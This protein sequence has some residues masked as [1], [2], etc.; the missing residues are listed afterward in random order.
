MDDHREGIR[1]EKPVPLWE[2]PGCRE[3]I[4]AEQPVLPWEQSGGFR[5]DCEPHRGKF[6]WW[7]ACASYVVGLLALLPCVGFWPGVI[8][9]PFNLG[10]RYLAGT[11]LA[12]PAGTDP[13]RRAG[14]D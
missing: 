6:L 4:Q 13:P 10:N 9:I 7:L 2:R 14:V 5:L 1:I 3:A 12:N 8:G 11:D